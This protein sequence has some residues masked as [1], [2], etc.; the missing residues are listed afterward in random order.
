MWVTDVPRKGHLQLSGRAAGARGHFAP[1][2]LPWGLWCTVSAGVLQEGRAHRPAPLP[3]AC[4]G[5]CPGAVGF[6]RQTGHR[7]GVLRCFSLPIFCSRCV[8]VQ[9]CA[10]GVQEPWLGELRARP[11]HGCREEKWCRRMGSAESLGTKEL[12]C[13]KGERF[14]CGERGG[15]RSWLSTQ[16]GRKGRKL[17]W[18]AGRLLCHK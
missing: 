12:I 3:S 14:M 1:L 8:G 2:G 16:R 10:C 4:F 9:V 15:A 6:H 17:L 5:R 7:A 13:F 18:V 11:G